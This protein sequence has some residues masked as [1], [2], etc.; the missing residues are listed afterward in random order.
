MNEKVS[1]KELFDLRSLIM[2]ILGVGAAVFA[3]KGFMV[4]NGFLDGGIT[5]ISLLIHEIYHVNLSLLIIALNIPF[6]ILV[7]KRM[8]LLVTLRSVI[9]IVLLALGLEFIVIPSVTA[10]KLL[11]SIFGGAS[12]GLGIGLVVRGA[13]FIDGLEVIASIATKRIGFST[14]E[15]VLFINSIIFAV[16]AIHFGFEIAMYAVITYY[17][18]SQTSNYIVDGIEEF[19]SLTI[20]SSKEDEVKALIVKKYGK[21]ISVI[22]GERGYLPGSFEQKVDSQIIVTILTRLEVLPIKDDIYEID[23]NAFMY[24]SSIKEVKGGVI[25][26]KAAH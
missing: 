19:T 1:F 10:D 7:Y 25:K 17:T 15:V 6:I 22:N 20:I 16:A 11:I 24:V 13:G 12:I 2:I 21:G 14:G 5:G 23:P 4:P 9:A 26:H 3:I 18:A 8:G